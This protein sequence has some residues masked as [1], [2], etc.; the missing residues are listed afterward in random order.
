VTYKTRGIIIKRIN[1]GEADKIITFYTATRGKMRARAIGVRKQESKLAGSLE[2]FM[3]SD[4]ILARGR[5]LD[6]VTS[7]QAINSFSNLRS[8]LKKT[9]FAYFSI[10]LIE[11][12]VPEELKDTRIFSLLAE[13]LK[14][15][16]NSKLKSLYYSAFLLAFE[17]RLLNFLGFAP[18]ISRCLHCA[19][20][21]KLAKFYF[22][23]QLGGILCENC[24][25]YDPTALPISYQEIELWNFLCA[26]KK[27]YLDLE[28]LK[29]DLLLPLSQKIDYFLYF[30]FGKNIKS[31]EFIRQVA[32]LER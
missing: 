2:L 23:A 30:I 3:H 19:E 21:G 8:D 28:N 13:T 7:A 29:M 15:L 4:L 11:K 10:E 32:V 26:S 5:N 1:L 27:D 20:N 25:N 9:S 24:K 16:N 17:I 31:A 22:S 14:V 6:V 12:F 18:Q